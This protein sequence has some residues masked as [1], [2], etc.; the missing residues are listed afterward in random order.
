MFAVGV[1]WMQPSTE[2][3]NFIFNNVENEFGI[4]QW[5]YGRGA[6]N[7]VGFTSSEQTIRSPDSNP[8]DPGPFHSQSFLMAQCSEAAT[9]WDSRK[10]VDTTVAQFAG[11]GWHRVGKRVKGLSDYSAFLLLLPHRVGKAGGTPSPGI[12]SPKP[13]ALRDQ[14]SETWFSP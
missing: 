4:A 1:L 11:S 12:R 10:P 7:S 14:A 3:S 2:S 8:E 5:P 13:F 6:E 9:G